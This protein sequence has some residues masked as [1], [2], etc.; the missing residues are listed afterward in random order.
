MI[1]DTED[2]KKRRE[3]LKNIL[4]GTH[5]KIF[6]GKKDIKNKLIIVYL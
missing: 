2:R 5:G 1:K 6:K 3:T 4:E